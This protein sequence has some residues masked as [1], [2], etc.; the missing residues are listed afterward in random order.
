[1]PE[2][3]RVLRPAL[4]VLAALV[5][6]GPQLVGCA[7]ERRRPPLQLKTLNDKLPGTYDNS[8]QVAQ[9]LAHGVAA[10]HLALALL[11]APAHA[12]AISD[13][14][15]YVRQSVA[16]DPRRVLSQRLWMLAADKKKQGIVQT[17]YVF[18]EPLRWISAADEPQLLLSLTLD[19]LEELKGCDLAWSETDGLLRAVAAQNNCRPAALKEGMLLEQ[20]VAIT[21][22]ELALGEAEVGADGKVAAPALFDSDVDFYRFVRRASSSHVEPGA[23]P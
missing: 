5:L 20:R 15:L 22:D 10:P 16:G 7:H 12:V 13:T 23:T 11:V 18:K 17:M 2:P 1:M 9:D 3:A 6:A 4:L 8:A 14:M 19:D 21:G